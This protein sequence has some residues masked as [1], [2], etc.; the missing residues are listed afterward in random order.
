MAGTFFFLHG[1]DI[2]SLLEPF[3]Q[4]FS[5]SLFLVSLV[6][7]F[8]FFCLYPSS[9]LPFYQE[10]SGFIGRIASASF[11][12]RRMPDAVYK[13]RLTL[14]IVC[15]TRRAKAFHIFTPQNRRRHNF[16]FSFSC[17][18]HIFLYVR[19][20]GLGVYLKFEMYKKNARC[21]HVVTKGRNDSVIE[22]HGLTK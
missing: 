7:Q 19:S 17:L 5:F 1:I 12:V 16:A 22:F 20:C 4:T 9:M 6:R 3:F 10:T 8:F 11:S 14:N 15:Y 13:G 18:G 2:F 21:T